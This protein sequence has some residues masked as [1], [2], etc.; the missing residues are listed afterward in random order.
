[1]EIRN[2]EKRNSDFALLMRYVKNS[3]PNDYSYNRRINGLIRL[4]ERRQILCGEL[5]MRNGLLRENRAKDCQEIEELRRIC[6]EETDR[7][8]RARIDKVSMQQGRNPTTVS[9]LLTQIQD[10]QN[11]VNSLSDA[12]EF[13]DPETASSPGASHVP[14]QRLTIP[15]PRTM[16]CRESGL[17]LDTRNI[18]GT[19]GNVFERLTCSRRTTLSSLRKF[20]QLGIIFSRIE[21]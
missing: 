4:T 8:R 1:M 16:P 5:E 19:S 7:A 14:S 11:K 6:C 15:S 18:M 3:N 9:Q 13:Y 20:K 12:R 2:W 10:L 21:T 17:P